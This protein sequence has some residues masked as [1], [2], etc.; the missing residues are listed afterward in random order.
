[1]TLDEAEQLADLWNETPAGTRLM[2][3]LTLADHRSTAARDDDD[4]LL[5]AELAG[6][7]HAVS[8]DELLNRNRGSISVSNVGV[9][10]FVGQAPQSVRHELYWRHSDQP[11]F[12]AA[13]G[14]PVV[15]RHQSQLRQ[16]STIEDVEP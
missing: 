4:P 15:T 10:S 5:E 13:A 12:G 2:K 9:V 3:A 14:R 16:P 1:M 8:R 6:W 7:W 11:I